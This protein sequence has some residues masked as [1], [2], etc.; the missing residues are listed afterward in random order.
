[1]LHNLNFN[2]QITT[3]PYYVIYF[4]HL[5]WGENSM[6]KFKKMIMEWVH[7]KMV[8]VVLTIGQFKK[9]IFIKQK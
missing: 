9:S 6:K 8:E 1:M 4:Y 5:L 3:E 2:L 7:Q